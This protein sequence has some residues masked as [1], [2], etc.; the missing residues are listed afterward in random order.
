M[1][2]YYSILGRQVGSHYLAIATLSTL[3]GGVYIA[4]SG[5]SKKVAQLPPINA[6]SPD[7]ADFVKKF[8]EEA[9]G[10]KKEAH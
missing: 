8:I 6:G 4:S 7:E 9:D 2:A 1:V 10:K 3:F 5:P